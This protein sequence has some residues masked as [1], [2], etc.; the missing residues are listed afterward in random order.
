MYLRRLILEVF[1]HA[2]WE[3]WV[4]IGLLSLALTGFLLI[5]KKVSVY[6]AICLGVTVFMGLF[7][8]DTAVLIR[9]GD[10]VAHKTGFD[11]GYELHY[12]LFGGMVRWTEMFANIAVFVP[13]GFF[14]SEFLSMTKRF[15]ASSAFSARR[16]MG[17]VALAAFGLSICIESL[18][19]IL[20]LGVFEITDLVLNT[21]GGVIGA[22]V[23]GRSLSLSKGRPG[24]T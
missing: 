11:P 23:A 3:H 2:R 14:L 5:R 24:R 19:L 7:L 18:Q 1:A 4:I 21:V 10:G 15:G 12:F 8:L 6:G 16:Q 9:I 22:W 13:F 20:R 17:R